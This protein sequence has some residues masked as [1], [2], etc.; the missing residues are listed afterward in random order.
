MVGSVWAR[1]RGALGLR[2]SCFQGIDASITTPPPPLPFLLGTGRAVPVPLPC[3]FP[4]ASQAYLFMFFGVSLIYNDLL[5]MQAPLGP[6]SGDEPAATAANAGPAASPPRAAAVSA[7]AASTRPAR[8]PV[9][10][11]IFAVALLMTLG[12]VCGFAVAMAP[13]AISVAKSVSTQALLRPDVL[14]W[15]L[16]SVCL[17]ALYR[18]ERAARVKAVSAV[19]AQRQTD[20]DTARLESYPAKCVGVRSFVWVQVCERG[21]FFEFMCAALAVFEAVCERKREK[22]ERYGRVC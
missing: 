4:C 7:L 10:L 11:I 18:R 9:A 6:G 2:A 12:L 21:S 1:V 20:L 22:R 8:S 19:D 14:P 13:L 15:I 16:L 3:P 5:E 17:T